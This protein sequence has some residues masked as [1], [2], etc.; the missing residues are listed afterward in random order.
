MVYKKRDIKYEERVTGSKVKFEG[1]WKGEK[2]TEQ[3]R[4]LNKRGREGYI[5]IRDVK[6]RRERKV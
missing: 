6:G 5:T 3:Y 4:H 2:G 1:K